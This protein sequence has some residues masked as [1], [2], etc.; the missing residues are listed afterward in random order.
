MPSQYV[1]YC[2]GHLNSSIYCRQLLVLQLWHPGARMP[3]LQHNVGSV[4]HGFHHA[5]A[6]GSMG[7][8]H[9]KT[10][11]FQNSVNRHPGWSVASRLIATASRPAGPSP[12]LNI[13]Q[14]LVPP[15]GSYDRSSVMCSRKRPKDDGPRQLNLAA[16]PASYLARALHDGRAEPAP[17]PQRRSQTTKG[18][19]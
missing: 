2:M 12:R 3:K 17:A 13:W 18:T 1:T 15:G 19:L 10:K 9:Y 11:V 6:P 4:G 7:C 16:P 14:T 8:M 5:P